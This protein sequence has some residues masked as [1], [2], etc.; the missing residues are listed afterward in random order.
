MTLDEVIGRVEEE[1]PGEAE[2]GEMVRWISQLDAKWQ[3]EVIDTHEQGPDDR[4]RPFNHFIYRG[5]VERYDHPPVHVTE[6][7]DGQISHAEG[8]VPPPPP[9]PHGDHP[10]PDRYAVQPPF[11]DVEGRFSGYSRDF[12]GARV[13]LIPPPWDEAYV[14]YLYAQMDQRLGEI[15]RYNND[16]ALFNTTYEEARAY[17]NRTHMPLNVKVHG[18]VYGRPLRPR[19]PEEIF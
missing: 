17:Y 7:R 18:V 11:G 3:R 6:V 8:A 13:L 16:A 2:K 10:D 1:R 12:D 9:P 5:G 19:G 4:R 15:E 14:Y